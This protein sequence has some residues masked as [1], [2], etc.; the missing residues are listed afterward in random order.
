M[1]CAST[2]G[3]VAYYPFDGNANDASGN[4]NNGTIFGGVA[5]TADRFGN[6][7]KAFDFN[8]FDGKIYT[9]DIINVS[10]AISISA[11][12]YVRSVANGEFSIVTEDNPSNGPFSLGISKSGNLF[13]YS[14]AYANGGW[15][16][17][18]SHQTNEDLNRW[19]HIALVAGNGEMKLYLDGLKVFTKTTGGINMHTNSDYLKIG[20]QRYTNEIANGKMDDIYI[21]NRVITDCE[22]KKLYDCNST[23][24]SPHVNCASTDNLVAYY[25]FDGNA[26]DASGNGNNGSIIGA[27][28]SSGKSGNALKFSKAVDYVEI[29][30]SNSMKITGTGISIACWL[31]INGGGSEFPRIMLGGSVNTA[32]TFTLFSSGQNNP[33]DNRLFFRPVTTN[34]TFGSI[35]SNTYLTRNIWYHVVAYYDGVNTRLYINGE[36]DAETTSIN[37]DLLTNDFT[38]VIGGEIIP[39][40]NGCCIS[41]LDGEIDELRLYGRALTD[42]EIKKLYDCNS[43]CSS[44]LVASYP[45]CGNANDVSGNNNNGTVSGATLTTDRFGNANSAYS[46]DG[47]DDYIFADASYNLKTFTISFWAKASIDILTLQYPVLTAF[48][49]DLT[50]V[51][52]SPFVTQVL[53]SPYPINNQGRISTCSYT[54]TDLQT[55]L[56]STDKPNTNIWHHYVITYNTQNNISIYINN[57]HEGTLP[58]NG[59]SQKNY[60]FL[61]IGKEGITSFYNSTSYK[62]DIDDIRIYSKALSQAEITALYN[63]PAPCTTTGGLV[64]HYPFCGNAVDKSGNNNH[65]TVSGATLTTDRFGNA[66][67]AYSFDGVNDLIEIDGQNISLNKNISMSLWIKTLSSDTQASFAGLIDRSHNTAF[68]SGQNWVIQKSNTVSNGY[69]FTYN[70]AIGLNFSSNY[71]ETATISTN[72][73]NWEHL[74]YTKSNNIIKCYKNGQLISTDTYSLDGSIVPNVNENILIGSVKYFSNRFFKGSIDDIKIYDKALSQAEITAIYNEPPPCTTTGGLVAHYPFCGNADDKSGNNNHGTV[75]GATLTTDRFGNANS[76][77]SFQSSLYQSILIPNRVNNNFS[78]SFWMQSS[79]LGISNTTWFNGRGIIS[80]EYTGCVRDFGSALVQNGKIQF[81]VGENNDC[82]PVGSTSSSSINNGQWNHIVLTRNSSN[83]SLSVYINGII[84]STINSY[85]TSLD[86]PIRIAFGSDV[87]HAIL[88]SSTSQDFFYSGKIDDIKIYDKALS[89]TEITA[90]YNEPAPCTTTGLVASYPFCGNADDKSGNNYNGTVSGA[91]LTTDRFGNA[92][93]AYSFDGNSNYIESNGNSNFKIGNDGTLSV[94]VKK[95]VWNNLPFVDNEIINN[96]FSYTNPNSIYLSFHY[97]EGIHFRFKNEPLDYVNSYIYTNWQNNTWHHIVGKWEKNGNNTLISLYTDGVLQESK[98][99]IGNINLNNVKWSFGKY[100]TNKH[101]EW[102]DG[103]IDDIKIYDKALSQAEITALFNEPAFCPVKICPPLTITG[104]TSFCN[105]SSGNLK[106]YSVNTITGGNYFWFLSGKYIGSGSNI[107]I[108]WQEIGNYTLTVIPSDICQGNAIANISV[109]CCSSPSIV[110]ANFDALET[111]CGN[112]F[113]TITNNSTGNKFLWYFGENAFPK[114]FSGYDPPQIAYKKSAFENIKLVVSNNCGMKDSLTKLISIALTPVAFAGKDINE[115]SLDDILLGAKPIGLYEYEWS[116]AISVD[117][118]F[119][120]NPKLNK[121]YTGKIYLQT[122]CCGT[123]C[124]GSDTLLVSKLD[125]SFTTFIPKT[126][127]SICEDVIINVTS[128]LNNN[129]FLWNTG[130]TFSSLKV[131]ESGIYSVKTYNSCSQKTDTVQVEI[132]KPTDKIPN[133]ITPNGDKFNDVLA[134][135]GCY[136]EQNPFSLQ[137]FSRSGIKVYESDNYKNNWNAEGLPDG[138]YYFLTE[139]TKSKRVIKG[140]IEIIR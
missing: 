100:L 10:T 74:V 35:T 82:N 85:T 67:S 113:F 6:I 45:F 98:V 99:I 17:Y 19:I 20:Y 65:G 38:K 136:F 66:N 56:Q 81:G 49:Y 60:N 25:P 68:G 88:G 110:E 133:V 61:T 106:T 26:N 94:W 122:K 21:Y 118:K 95:D 64:A 134:F 40:S 127:Q 104:A 62:G 18:F 13:S 5:P 140:W 16:D 86:Y 84:E 139:S 43:T 63:E 44:G 59:N 116:P 51:Y 137:I 15:T 39:H 46:F 114:T 41:W 91:T 69:Y 42:C 77:Y 50:N 123:D 73:D 34:S 109:N 89:Q 80:A 87:S 112:T 23:C 3:L 72:Q 97:L 125:S 57:Q 37:G 30:N 90:L 115:C 130:S 131:S 31:K 117:D 126:M 29:P 27:S 8:G 75:S 14:F 48:K 124:I 138:I 108:N 105:S 12:V 47:I 83:G 70:K 9:N 103:S 79:Q 121:N 33:T 22:I 129:R 28:F 24:S 107:S 78:I 96:N 2:D 32:Y 120:S 71:G 4:G 92:N 111:V 128:S 119:K 54:N 1:S 36:K 55:C 11:W 93:S 58:I 135:Y 132:Q 53:A 52:N 102:M 101:Q 76:A 7:N